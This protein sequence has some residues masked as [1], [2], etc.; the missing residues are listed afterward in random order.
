VAGLH[1]KGR[2]RRGVGVSRRGLGAQEAREAGQPGLPPPTAGTGGGSEGKANGGVAG[3]TPAASALHAHTQT[4]ETHMVA[5][6]VEKRRCATRSWCPVVQPPVC[7]RGT[8]EGVVSRLRGLTE[9]PKGA[10]GD[11]PS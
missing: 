6:S 1:S 5:K 2:Q 8:D 10:A 11:M 3:P 9:G 4:L 7:G